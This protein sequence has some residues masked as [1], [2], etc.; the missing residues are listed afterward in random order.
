MKTLFTLILTLISVITYGQVLN[1]KT[2]THLGIPSNTIFYSI[3]FDDNGNVYVGTQNGVYKYNKNNPTDE[4]VYNESSGLT[5]RDI[6]FVKYVNGNIIAG[7]QNGISIF[8]GTTWTN[9]TTNST[10]GKYVTSY[11]P[12]NNVN[13]TD[14]VGGTMGV[15]M[16]MNDGSGNY[17]VGTITSPISYNSMLLDITRR[18]NAT[19]F[20]DHIWYASVSPQAIVDWDLKNDIKTSYTISSIASNLSANSDFTKFVFVA[21]GYVRIFDVATKTQSFLTKDG[22]AITKA[23]FATYDNDGNIWYSYTSD[24]KTK[25][26]KYDGTNYSHGVVVPTGVRDI[27]INTDGDLYLATPKGLYVYDYNTTPTISK[28]NITETDVPNVP[29]TFYTIE[30]D[31]ASYQWYYSDS[32]PENNLNARVETTF[33]EVFGATSYSYEPSQAGYYKVKITQTSGVSAESDAMLFGTLTT[34]VENGVVSESDLTVYPNPNVG[35][36]NISTPFD[37]AEVMITNQIGQTEKVVFN[38]SEVSTTMKGLVIV[39]IKTNK[40]VATKRMVIQ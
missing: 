30:L 3:D 20:E 15:A 38:G 10:G 7:R 16:N 39:T 4:I 36:F 13:G 37:V 40:G 5:T 32:A 34:G 26:E 2:L 22:V 21:G 1:Q 6:R 25:V 33:T 14:Y 35:T 27:K 28:V 31:N 19:N 9:H 11:L 8:N 18:G 17:A 23:T 29:E 24:L 12:T